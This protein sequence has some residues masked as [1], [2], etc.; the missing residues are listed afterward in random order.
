MRSEKAPQISCFESLRTS[1][2]MLSLLM[3]TRH[4]CHRCRDLDYCRKQRL[5]PA[6]TSQHAIIVTYHRSV[7]KWN[8]FIDLELIIFPV[9][10]GCYGYGSHCKVFCYWN[11]NVTLFRVSA[12]QISVFSITTESVIIEPWKALE[13]KPRKS[14]KSAWKIC[15][16]NLVYT[17]LKCLLDFSLNLTGKHYSFKVIF[18]SWRHSSPL[19][20]T[21]WIEKIM[22]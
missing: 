14:W 3:C 10:L 4:A 21:W 18:R 12:N 13:N 22:V 8:V 2:Y 6:G 11:M 19:V 9:Q 17:W 20:C 7:K 5:G 15:C 1:V 16:A